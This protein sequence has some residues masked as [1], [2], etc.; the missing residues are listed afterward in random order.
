MINQKVKK[1]EIVVN[2]P[3]ISQL[4]HHKA[5]TNIHDTDDYDLNSNSDL[6]IEINFLK[7]DRSK[8]DI[9]NKINQSIF[10]R[11]KSQ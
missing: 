2:S 6:N 1:E 10:I 7:K 8:S 11:F 3:I 9:N 4:L 5:R